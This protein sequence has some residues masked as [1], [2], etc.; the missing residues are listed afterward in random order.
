MT[1]LK[2]ISRLSRLEFDLVQDI[3]MNFIGIIDE[4]RLDLAI[5]GDISPAFCQLFLSHILLRL[6]EIVTLC[7][8]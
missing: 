2:V 8:I 7:A 5:D 4:K 1:I 3:F 6:V